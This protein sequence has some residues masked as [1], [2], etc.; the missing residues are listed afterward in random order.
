MPLQATFRVGVFSE[1]LFASRLE[2]KPGPWLS[3]GCLAFGSKLGRTTPNQPQTTADEGH[4][5][6]YRKAEKEI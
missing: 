6:W 5:E 4:Q 2:L 1:Y 3:F